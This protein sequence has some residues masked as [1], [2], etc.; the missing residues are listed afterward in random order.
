MTHSDTVW[1]AADHHFT[2]TNLGGTIKRCKGPIWDAPATLPAQ[3]ARGKGTAQFNGSRNYADNTG[4]LQ[5]VQ[6]IDNGIGN[7]IILR[8]FNPSGGKQQSQFCSQP[9][10]IQSASWITDSGLFQERQRWR[11]SERP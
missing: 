3:I 6:P 1:K 11:I 9:N 8:G 4:S 2:N 5:T 10:R 7:Q